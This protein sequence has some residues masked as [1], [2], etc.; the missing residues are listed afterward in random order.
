MNIN[1]FS[2]FFKY[3][4]FKI[5]INNVLPFNLINYLF[6]KDILRQLIRLDLT[7]L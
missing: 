2:N 7:N 1:I 6:I 3:K 5:I 4:S